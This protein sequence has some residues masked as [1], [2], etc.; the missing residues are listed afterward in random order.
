M[1]WRRT[2]VDESWRRSC[3]R[4]GFGETEA[5]LARQAALK[6]V[7]RCVRPIAGVL[8]VRVWRH[9]A[10]AGQVWL[11]ATESA[12][13]RE[14]LEERTQAIVRRSHR[15]RRREGG[16]RMSS[17][18]ARAKPET[19]EKAGRHVRRPMA[20]GPSNTMPRRGC[21]SVRPPW[22]PL[23]T[24]RIRCAR[25]TSRPL[26][27]PPPCPARATPGPPAPPSRRSPSPASARMP[28]T[29]CPTSTMATTCPMPRPRW[30][31][32]QSA[33]WTRP[34]GITP[35][36]SSLSPSRWPRRCCRST[37]PPARRRQAY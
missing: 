28:A 3:R 30:P 10:R 4:T 11:G 24:L 23:A 20:V 6:A 33:S 2:G 36:S 31:S 35:A 17:Q 19:A 8:L 27:P 15:A 9:G 34:S 16:R 25:T 29:S 37:K 32:T 22:P 14:A 26:S 5:S 1:P 18:R 21:L 7:D 12:E 13:S